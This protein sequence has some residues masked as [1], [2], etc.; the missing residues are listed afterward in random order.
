[1][2]SFDLVIKDG[3]VFDGRRSPR[4]RGDIG[5]ADGV[6]TAIGSLRA[7]DGRRVIDA[8]GLN[9]AP[10]FI[11]LHTHYDSQLFWDPYCSISGW[12][13]VTSIVI[14]NCGFGFAP[15]EPEGRERAMQTMSR[16][17]AV[18]VPCMEQGMPWDWVTFPEFL[19]SVR[20]A[21]KAINV[22]A[23]VPL[24][25]L[26]VWT[27]GLDRAKAGA[28]PSDAEHDEMK[29]LLGEAMDAGAR[30]YSAQRMGPRS[31]QRDYDG[32]PMVTDI[33]HD[34]TMLA[35]GEVLADRRDGII[36]YM[37]TTLGEEGVPVG[38]AGIGYA[39]ARVKQHVEALAAVSGAPIIFNQLNPSPVTGPALE[40]L[41]SC[42]E[43]GLRIY[44]QGNTFVSSSISGNLDENPA[45]L[46]FSLA[47]CE[48]TT[49]SHDDV[50][51]KISDPATRDK[52]R[53]DRGTVESSIGPMGSWMLRRGVTEE[54]AR[55]DGMRLHD[56]AEA[57]GADDL[58]DVFC[59]LTLAGDLRT[60]WSWTFDQV[61]LDVIKQL[62]DDTYVL[63]G[64]SDG[65]AHTKFLTAGNYGTGW[66][67]KYVRDLEWLSLEDAH[68]RLSGLPGFCAGFG[69][70]GTLVE[71]APADIIVYDHERLSTGTQEVAQDYPGGE[72]RLITRPTGYRHIL[73]NGEVIVEDDKETGAYAG[74]VL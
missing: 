9:V 50:V 71:G 68:W 70:R 44:G 55:F 39:S 14:G 54:T 47:W 30:G 67:S 32:T 29:R 6:I 63:P 62:I 21:P 19:G 17:E 46:D 23:L 16:N 3:L 27:M 65:G 8:S 36:Q 12:H 61:N 34:E 43:R 1:M 37:Y 35:L 51:R 22:M 25:P 31:I 69:S 10:G 5:I 66:L 53:A 2:A 40:W 26:M 18:P 7:S 56:I 45:L 4:F 48:A 42:R 57:T 58:V 73:V 52:I 20:R 24:T 60:V 64:I 11:D 13:G 15:V 33:M 74:A 41:A 59:D 72:W 38:P 49:G 28:L